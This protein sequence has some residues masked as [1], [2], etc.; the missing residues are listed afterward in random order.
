M[1]F[2][3]NGIDLTRWHNLLQASDKKSDLDAFTKT[4]RQLNVANS[5]VIDCTG[6]ESTVQQYL[7]LL[8]QAFP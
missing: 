3:E 1:L 8:I 2:D 6:I 7:P 4:V 5:I